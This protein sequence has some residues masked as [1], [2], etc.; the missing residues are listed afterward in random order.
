M[1]DD[2]VVPV[3]IILEVG[4]AGGAA[5]FAVGDMMGLAAGGGLVAA[6]GML[7]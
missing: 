3:A 5:V 1:Q 6:A 4:Q 2:V 7:P